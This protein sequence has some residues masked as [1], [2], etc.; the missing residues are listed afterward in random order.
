MDE[1]KIQKRSLKEYLKIYA[2]G[3]VMGAADVVPGVSG[4]T[5]A[6]IL[7]IY[8]ELIESIK[9]FTSPNTIRMLLKFE[10]K[11]AWDTLPWRFLVTLIAG[12]G[13]AILLLS[14]AIVWMLEHRFSYTMAFFFG[15]ILASIFTVWNRVHKWSFDRYIA[16]LIGAVGAWFLVGLPMANNPPDAWWYIVMCGAIAIC[17][18]ILPGIS[19]SFILLLLGRYDYIFSA[20]N[21]CK[22]ALLAMDWKTLLSQGLILACFAIGIVLGISSFVRLLSWLFKKYND[23][24]VAVLI[25]FMGG[26]LRK[27]W[28]WQL[29]SKNILPEKFDISVWFVIALVI[30]GFVLVVVLERLAAKL[31]KKD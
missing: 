26:A 21:N 11:K 20:I 18:M 8:N 10:I 1:N 6:F 17:A 13:T 7:G 3:F 12:I 9:T 29:N 30:F 31:E 5:M 2:S 28:P 27:V 16:V 24:T 23:W 22:S 25:G 15:L 19:G 4:G 14:G